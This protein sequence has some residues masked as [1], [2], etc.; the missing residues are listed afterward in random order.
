MI[1]VT[2]RIVAKRATRCNIYSQDAREETVWY[3]KGIGESGLWLSDEK[4][5]AFKSLLHPSIEADFSITELNEKGEK[6]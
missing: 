5:R 4:W 2:F 6:L 3:V 1:D